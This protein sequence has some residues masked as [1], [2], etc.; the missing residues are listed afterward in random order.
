MK[1]ILL[2]I[3][4]LPIVCLAQK[5]EISGQVGINNPNVL[6][7]NDPFPN[8]KQWLSYETKLGYNVCKHLALH[9]SFE[10]NEGYASAAAIGIGADYISKHF[11]TGGAVKR[12]TVNDPSGWTIY[13]NPAY[14][15]DLHAGLKQQLS[16]H[17]CVME[18]MGG[19]II[20]ASGKQQETGIIE[21]YPW[22]AVP[23][24][25]VYYNVSRQLRYLYVRIGL[26]YKL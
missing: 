21:F 5:W 1:K 20:N 7:S 6:F 23:T 14:G 12:A 25:P 8:H 19:E 11:F 26:A 22:Y 24:G 10:H 13:N 2:L 18:Q 4:F 15:F 3:A 17:W 16:G 9:V